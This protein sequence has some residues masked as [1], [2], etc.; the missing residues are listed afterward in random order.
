MVVWI[1]LKLVRNPQ[2]DV[3]AFLELRE[4]AGLLFLGGD[5]RKS[6]PEPG[7]VRPASRKHLRNN[8]PPV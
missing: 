5:D 7:Q 1:Y 6:L 2:A 8:L 4:G 3:G